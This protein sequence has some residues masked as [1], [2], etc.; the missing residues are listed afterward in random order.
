MP[1]EK[2]NLQKRIESG[3]RIVLAEIAPPQSADGARVR[4]AAKSFSGK[5]HALGVC[6]NRDGVRMSALAAAS[7]ILSE[8][9]EPVLHMTTRDRNRTALISE[10]LGAQAMGIK[11]VLCTSGTHQSLLPF[12]A[13]KNVYDIDATIL[14]QSLKGLEKNASI[15]GEKSIDG[16]LPFCL[17]AVA[18]PYADPIELQLP[19]LAQ[20]IFAGA[21]FIITQPIF[22][23]DRFNI[24]WKEVSNRGLPEKAAFIAGIKV[25]ISGE[26]AKAYAEKRPLP[27]VPE[28]MITRLASKSD[29]QGGR[30]E[31]IKIALETIE[32]LSTIN[33]LRGFEI[34][35]DD[36]HEVALE[37]LESLAPIFKG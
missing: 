14:L 16:P 19:R 3:N 31:G 37:I 27:M 36:D 34:A 24:W 10:S 1:Y 20:K 25:L 11:N 35:C 17:G 28:A 12:H 23:L 6:D 5:V 8:G 9:V 30:K 2:S 4:A 22:D 29:T 33:G 18:S 7:I 15:V 21:Q 26:S 32:K 13:A